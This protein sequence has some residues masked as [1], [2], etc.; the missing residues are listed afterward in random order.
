MAN[1]RIEQIHDSYDDVRRCDCHALNFDG[2]Q[3]ATVAE[4]EHPRDDR[5][6]MDEVKKF[7]ILPERH[8]KRFGW[9][10]KE[11]GEGKG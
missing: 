5:E 8:R 3:I 11:D 9:M 10:M 4:F 2:E 1:R 7:K 6:A